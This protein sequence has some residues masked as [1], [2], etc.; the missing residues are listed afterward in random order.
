[1][2]HYI[3]GN[4]RV[5]KTLSIFTIFLNPFESSQTDYCPAE[6]K[7]VWPNLTFGICLV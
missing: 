7:S 2:L 5:S 3:V 4:N 1:M 6:L